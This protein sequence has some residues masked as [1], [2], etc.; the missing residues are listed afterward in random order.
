MVIMVV[1]VVVVVKD[2]GEG[3]GRGAFEGRVG[4]PEI[5][6]LEANLSGA[7]GA[8]G[9]ATSTCTHERDAAGGAGDRVGVDPRH[10]GSILQIRGGTGVVARGAAEKEAGQKRTGVP[11]PSRAVR[12]RRARERTTALGARVLVALGTGQAGGRRGSTRIGG[13]AGGG[14]QK[15]VSTIGRCAPRHHCAVRSRCRSQ[16]PD[17][18]R[19]FVSGQQTVYV[20]IVSRPECLDQLVVGV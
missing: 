7:Q 6:A 8:G 10:R 16:G 11:N 20:E 17:G 18:Q 2:V 12:G 4:V 15:R 9:V 3:G 14:N 5:T 1:M 13:G 19:P